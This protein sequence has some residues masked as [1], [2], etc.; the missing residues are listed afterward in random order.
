M[1][2]A[3]SCGVEEKTGGATTYETVRIEKT[4]SVCP[5]C[6]DYS[7]ANGTKPI[8]VMSCEGACLRGEV[9]RRAARPPLSRACS[10]KDGT[11]LPRGRLYQGYR[12]K[13]AR[14]KRGQGRCPGRL[15][16]RVCEQDDERGDSRTRAGGNNRGPA[17]RLRPEP[18]RDKRYGG[19]RDKGTRAH[20]GNEGR[21]RGYN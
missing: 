21:V 2:I 8:V 10:R 15:L 7:R 14:T 16:H 18:L 1:D 13:G 17:L 20:S 9:A 3:N 19:G 5:M 4:K 12:A 6:E 11:P